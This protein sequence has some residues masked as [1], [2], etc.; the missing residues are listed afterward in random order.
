MDFDIQTGPAH[1]LL[2]L[3]PQHQTSN[4]RCSLLAVLAQAEEST[5]QPWQRQAQ[6]TLHTGPVGAG[7]QRCLALKTSTCYSTDQKP[8]SSEENK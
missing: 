1:V 2:G 7:P 8:S 6:Q 5:T 4:R 3:L